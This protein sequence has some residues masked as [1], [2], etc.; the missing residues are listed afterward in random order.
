MTGLIRVT[1]V[2][3]VAPARIIGVTSNKGVNPAPLAV[4]VLPR[5][6]MRDEGQDQI[7]TCA[8]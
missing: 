1:A 5:V 8:A 7:S 3:T 6:M 2:A 4:T